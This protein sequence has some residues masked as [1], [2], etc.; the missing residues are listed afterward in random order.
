M[1][2]I[3]VRHGR[4][5]AT[6]DSADPPLSDLGQQ[7]AQLVADRLLGDSRFPIDHVASSTMVRAHQTA[8]P[9]ATALGLEI[10]LRD[11]LREADEHRGRYRPME[12]MSPEDDFVQAYQNDP[13]S[14]FEEGY[15]AFRS[16][17]VG[18]F[19]AVIAANRGRTVAVFCHG[20]VIATYLQAT[21]DLADPFG[22]QMEYTGI[23]RVT[24]SS[25]GMRT[26]KS[27]NESGH[28]AHTLG[29]FSSDA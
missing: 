29:S 22:L 9:T 5:L 17:V 10:E 20:M 18:G 1:E 4:P 12:E 2:L 28:V 16:K 3:I 24:A 7:Q 23:M 15:E 26:V 19:E 27:V 8:M 25:T 11:D 6:D 21:W 13:Y 14:M